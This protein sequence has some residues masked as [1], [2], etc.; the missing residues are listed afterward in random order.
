MNEDI[1][2]RIKELVN[3]YKNNALQR[4]NDYSE[5]DV[6][7]IFIERFL[8][9]LGWSVDDVREVRRGVSTKSN[10]K[11]DYMLSV[12]GKAKFIIKVSKFNDK[13]DNQV[14]QAINCAKE[15]GVDWVILTNF[16]ET[17]LYYAQSSS[18]PLLTLKYS[19]YIDKLDD[20][21]LLSKEVIIEYET[22]LKRLLDKFRK[23]PEDLNQVYKEYANS[24]LD[25]PI[26]KIYDFVLTYFEILKKFN[27]K[28]SQYAELFNA[29]SYSKRDYEQAALPSTSNPIEVDS[30]DVAINKLLSLHKQNTYDYLAFAVIDYYVYIF[31]PSK[32]SIGAII[33]RDD[34]Y[35]KEVLNKALTEL[36]VNPKTEL[37]GL[38]GFM[39]YNATIKGNDIDVK[40]KIPVVKLDFSTKDLSK[41]KIILDVKVKDQC[42]FTFRENDKEV[43]YIA[44]TRCENGWEVKREF[45]YVDGKLVLANASKA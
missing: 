42:L 26:Y 27:L 31:T 9:A 2:E 5:D 7:A 16:A 15:L 32:Y 41:Y 24:S 23:L 45:R 38:V 40:P 30:K 12:D 39:G 1:K 14:S 6:K 34:N 4:A 13:L 37:G 17:R 29:I 20:I 43:K 33:V 21:L 3:E 44:I 25:L 18:D 11:V 19:E 35:A 8:K 22:R 36:N 28:P 10:N